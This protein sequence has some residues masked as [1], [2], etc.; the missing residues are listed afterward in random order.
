MTHRNKRRTYEH[1]GEINMHAYTALGKQAMLL[2]FQ[3][4]F[5]SFI[6]VAFFL[7]PSG[8]HRYAEQNSH[9]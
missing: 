6:C 3:L 1:Y 2:F 9:H 8:M 7:L 5:L 4:K